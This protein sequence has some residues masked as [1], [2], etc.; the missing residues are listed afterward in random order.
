M[1][2]MWSCDKTGVIKTVRVD[3]LKTTTWNQQEMKFYSKSNLK[4]FLVSSPPQRQWHYNDTSNLRFFTEHRFNY[5][6][7]W[8]DCSKAFNIKIIA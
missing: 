4:I 1:P 3:K 5:W 2:Q 6:P 7:V 8:F